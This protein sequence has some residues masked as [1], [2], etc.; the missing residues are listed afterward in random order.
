MCGDIKCCLGQCR[1][2]AG[3]VASYAALLLRISFDRV[4]GYTCCVYELENA[5]MWRFDV[6]EVAGVW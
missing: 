3:R 6:V 1:R 5:K 2:A 4:R